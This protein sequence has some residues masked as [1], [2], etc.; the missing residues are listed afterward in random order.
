MGIREVK[1]SQ[2]EFDAIDLAFENDGFAAFE[3]Q[4]REN[5]EY[6]GT[7]QPDGSIAFCIHAPHYYLETFKEYRR[8]IIYRYCQDNYDDGLRTAMPLVELAIH[9]FPNEMSKITAVWVE[10]EL[11]AELPKH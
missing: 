11:D 8:H 3:P 6:S 5:D 2:E 1:I 9:Y 4:L 7:A 10:K